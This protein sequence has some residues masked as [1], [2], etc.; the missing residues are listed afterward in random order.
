MAL[1]S[2]PRALLGPAHESRVGS[3]GWGQARGARR[4]EQAAWLALNH[5]LLRQT[6]REPEQLSGL[7]ITLKSANNTVRLAEVHT[8]RRM[9]VARCGEGVDM[10][11]DTAVGVEEGLQISLWAMR[12][13]VGGKT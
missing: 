12:R 11:F 4:A 3:I 1:D 6:L 13:W 7:S 9:I 5:P 10:L 8:V 2:S